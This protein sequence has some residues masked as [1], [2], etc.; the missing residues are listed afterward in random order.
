MSA[1]INFG[2][3]LHIVG[4]LLGA[5]IVFVD[6]TIVNVALPSL[7]VDFHASTASLE[8]VIN[9][10]TLVFA[11]F[12]LSVGSLADVLGARRIF[13]VGIIVFSLASVACATSSSISYLNVSRLVQ[14]LGAAL[15]LPSSLT[16]MTTD[17]TDERLRHRLVGFYAAAGGVGLAVGPLAGGL[18]IHGFGWPSIFWV[19][20]G[21]GLI[22]FAAGLWPT[23]VS[24]RSQKK[25]DYFGQFFATLAIASLVF[26]LVEAPERGWS[27]SLIIT[28]LPLFVVTLTLF[29]FVE[30]YAHSPLLPLGLYRNAQFF[31]VIGLGFFFNFMFYGVLFALSLYFQNGLGYNALLAGISFL[32][33]TG[34]VTA[35]NLVAPRVAERTH[36]LHVLIFGEA[37]VAA[38]LLIGALAGYCDLRLLLFAAL[39]PGGFGSGLLVPTMTS[40]TLVTV[41]IDSHGSATAGFNTFRQLGGAFGVSIFGPLV[42]GVADVRGGFVAS[43]FVAAG[44]MAVSLIV[45]VCTQRPQRIYCDKLVEEQVGE[46]APVTG[47]GSVR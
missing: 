3:T 26:A 44:A 9:A 27:D 17:V 12:L 13:L 36:R 1:T 10:Y 22:A 46:G 47:T 11:A 42:A 45:A 7:S 19:N 6:S 23:P 21:V 18:L 33:F 8:W 5:F 40:Q 38:S 20:V 16:I 39:L 25:I 43:L 30:R 2:R 34:L 35:G 29:I 31:G 37:L 32:P 24:T 28:S 41:P 15:V 4:G 14:G